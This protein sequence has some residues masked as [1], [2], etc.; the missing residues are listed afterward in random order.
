M[1]GG[2]ARPR[3]SRSD[4]EPQRRRHAPLPAVEGALLGSFAV[5]GVGTFVAMQWAVGGEEAPARD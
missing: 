4:Q 2:R 1:G 5:F 3:L